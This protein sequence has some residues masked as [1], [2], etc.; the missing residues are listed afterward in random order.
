MSRLKRTSPTVQ[1]AETRLASLKAID[2]EL[3]FGNGLSLADYIAEITALH[4]ELSAY[5]AKLSELDG[6]LNKVQAREKALR[7]YSS[8]MLAAVAARYGRDS[9]EYEQA[10]GT[11]TSERARRRRVVKE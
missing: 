6:L 4:A 9:N 7:A 11:R 3:D 10:G 2:E 8:R 1:E 5:N